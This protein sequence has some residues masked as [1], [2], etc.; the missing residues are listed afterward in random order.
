M[1]KFRL[2][3]VESVRC[4]SLKL[5]HLFQC[6]IE[7]VSKPPPSSRKSGA[8]LLNRDTLLMSYTVTNQRVEFAKATLEHSSKSIRIGSKR[9][10]NVQAQ[11]LNFLPIHELRLIF[12]LP[13]GKTASTPS[14]WDRQ[15]PGNKSRIS[16]LTFWPY[17]RERDFQR[18]L[19]V[20]FATKAT[21]ALRKMAKLIL[22]IPATLSTLQ[23]KKKISV[24]LNIHKS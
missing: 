14:Q 23:N 6:F 21:L 5:L 17:S 2:V 3:L 7:M 8:E 22:Q 12:K 15:K 13:H 9:E 11:L 20:S 19:T 18:H 24:L 1:T 16:G 10:T 4:K